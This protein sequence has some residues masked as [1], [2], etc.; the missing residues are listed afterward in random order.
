MAKSTQRCNLSLSSGNVISSFFSPAVDT[1]DDT[2]KG[3]VS[4]LPGSKNR[5]TVILRDVGSKTGKAKRFVEIWKGERRLKFAK[6]TDHHGAFITHSEYYLMS[7]TANAYQAVSTDYYGTLSIHEDAVFYS[8]EA[9]PRNKTVDIASRKTKDSFNDWEYKPGLGEQAASLVQPTIY[10]LN[11]NLSS[12]EEPTLSRLAIDDTETDQSLSTSLF[13]QAVFSSTGEDIFVTAYPTLL[14]GRRLGVAFCTNYP[15]IVYKASV[16]K[17]SGGKIGDKDAI[18]EN[19]WHPHKWTRLSSAGF[20]A[21]SPRSL[22][23]ENDCF[24]LQ[25]ESGGAH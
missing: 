15:S 14:D 23:E 10:L 2:I 13:G 18:A 4:S 1:G 24:F 21:R 20:S 8:A 12:G 3:C 9:K 22:G 19:L 7:T 25:S 17:D 6:V 11:F 5:W 16:E